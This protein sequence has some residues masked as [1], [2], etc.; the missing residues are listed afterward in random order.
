VSVVDAAG[1]L[2]IWIYDI[3]RDL[4]TRPTFDPAVDR[5]PVWSPEGNTIVWDRL[6][7]KGQLFRKAADGK[8]TEELIYEGTGVSDP[9][10]WSPDGKFLLFNTITP[11]MQNGVWSLPLTPEK[12]GI[13]LKASPL[14][15]TAF[16]EQNG[17]FSPDGHWVAYESNESSQNEVYVIPFPGPGGKR[18]ISIAGGTTPRWRRDG[19]EIFY[20]GLDRKLMAAEVTLKAGSIEAGQVRPLGIPVVPTGGI[21]Y[22][23]SL[24]GQ[25]FLVVAE[26]E[27]GSSPPLT[28]VQNW[29][30]L[31]KK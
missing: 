17:V 20:V 14:V 19:K 7:I 1:N 3:A 30:A 4:R 27:R 26:P 15:D 18:Q 10:S 12:P 2:D 23:I 9:T 21:R 28:L 13:P 6:R 22:D 16:N 11:G 31:L 25:R 24:D 29:T 5:R 8:G